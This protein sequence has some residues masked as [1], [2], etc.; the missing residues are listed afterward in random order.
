MNQTQRDFLIKQVETTCEEQ[1]N[2]LEKQRPDKPSLN[3]YII[4]AFLDNSIQFASID[5]LKNKMREEVLKFGTKDILI[6]EKQDYYG[7][8]K[9]KNEKEVVKVNAEDLFII[10]QNYLD[11]VE[12]YE[13]EYKRIQDKIE[14]L[15]NTLKTIVLKLQIGSA[16][17]LDKLIMQVDNMGDLNLVNTQLLISDKNKEQ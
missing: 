16:D 7:H 4:A 5:I 13:I 11:A 15:E 12:L 3:N 6:E 2:K 17:I 1:I 14:N 9:S 10:P 8:P